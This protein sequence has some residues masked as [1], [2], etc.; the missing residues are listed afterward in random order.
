MGIMGM[1]GTGGFGLSLSD[2]RLAGGG[3]GGSNGQIPTFTR[4][5]TFGRKTST[6]TGIEMP[7]TVVE[8]EHGEEESNSNTP[9][10][11]SPSTGTD[12]PLSYPYI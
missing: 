6:R 4:T 12:P 5:N 3:G 8:E 11:T 10:I 2:E 7:D 9:L 1:S